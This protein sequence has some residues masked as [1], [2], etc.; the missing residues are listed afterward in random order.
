[1]LFR[2][3]LNKD[4]QTTG[5][6]P[7]ILQEEDLEIL[8]DSIPG[9]EVAGK[10]SLTVALDITITQDLEN[11]GNAREFVNRIQQIRKE[12]NFE[13]TDKI[14]VKLVENEKI[15]PAIIEFKDYICAEILAEKLDFVTSLNE[16]IDLEVNDNPVKV[17]VT[18]KA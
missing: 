5:E 3:I 7:I 6:E 9:Y 16:G 4:Y 11:E 12:S 10:G 2:S 14:V 13:L 17:V 8:T 15:Q 18:K 1:M